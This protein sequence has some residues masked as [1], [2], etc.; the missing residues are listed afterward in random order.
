[1]GKNNF[2]YI[3]AFFKKWEGGWSVDPDDNGNKNNGCTMSGITLTTFKKYYG[4]E[5]T[6]DDLKKLT[7]AQW[8]NIFRKGYYD[9]C[10]CDS[11]NNPA[12]A[13]LVCQCA[14]GSGPQTAIKKIQNCLGCKADGIIGPITLQKINHPNSQY[15]FQR[16]WEMRYVW[17]CNIASVGNNKKFLKGWLRRLSDI[18]YIPTPTE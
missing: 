10:K 17:L 13:L 16:L 12:I 9:K 1:M 8:S 18:K 5:K 6:C 7:D 11:I 14:W 2:E 15:V 4:K 3:K